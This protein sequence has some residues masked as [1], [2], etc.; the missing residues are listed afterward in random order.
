MFHLSVTW[1][2]GWN[3][4]VVNHFNGILSLFVWCLWQLSISSSG[5]KTILATEDKIPPLK[6]S[7]LS[8]FP[9][10]RLK[11]RVCT[12]DLDFIDALDLDIF[13]LYLDMARLVIPIFIEW[14]C[15]YWITSYRG[16]LDSFVSVRFFPHEIF[17]SFWSLL[18]F[19]INII[20]TGFK[21][22]RKIV[23]FLTFEVN[24]L[25]SIYE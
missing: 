9:G 22:A 18:L 2:E 14:L 25:R 1:R 5:G 15:V 10:Q 4:L 6:F 24:P 23:R 19:V 20:K 16:G 7:Y 17:L 21:C 11:R 8:L 3:I 12:L 13:L